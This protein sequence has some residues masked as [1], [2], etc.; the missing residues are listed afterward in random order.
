MPDFDD[1]TNMQAENRHYTREILNKR[2]SVAAAITF[3]V[4]TGLLYLG[5]GVQSGDAQRDLSHTHKLA[6]CGV[7]HKMQARATSVPDSFSDLAAMPSGKDCLTCHQL[8]RL[9]KDQHGL[10]HYLASQSCLSCHSFHNP[11]LL[12][13]GE[14]TSSV[15]VAKAS[16]QVCQDCHIDKNIP[17]V[18]PGHRLAAQLIHGEREDKF[19][20]EPSEFCLACHNRDGRLPPEARGLRN[21]PRFHVSASHAY[22]IELVPGYR[23]PASTLKIQDEIPVDMRTMN[24]KL[25]C[26][27]CHSL[28]STN[29]YLLTKSIEN[30]L[31]TDCHDLGRKNP[32]ELVISAR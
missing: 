19:A 26:Q 7:C 28:S 10:F 20:K 29:D 24:G 21:F 23:R 16:I 2:R 17:E 18:S 27:S 14:K 22:G 32:A 8:S 3:I 30:G 15:S 13:I 11:D 9:S 31:C 6:D 5:W 1:N 4:A 12:R 25:E